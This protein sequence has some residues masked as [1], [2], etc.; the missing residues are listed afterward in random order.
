VWKGE[1]KGRRMEGKGAGKGSSEGEGRAVMPLHLGSLDPPEGRE[2]R[3]ARRGAWVEVSMPL[4]LKKCTNFE[5][6]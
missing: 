2:R 5:T 3:R 4:C 1:G 6:V